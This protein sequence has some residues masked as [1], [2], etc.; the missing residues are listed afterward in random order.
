M[1]KTKATP[2]S[3]VILAMLLL[4]LLASTACFGLQAPPTTSATIE[5]VALSAP[6][7]TVDLDALADTVAARVHDQLSSAAETDPQALRAAIQTVL[8]ESLPALDE[9]SL[10]QLIDEA[11]TNRLAQMEQRTAI[12]QSDA[13]SDAAEDDL[14]A[15]L[16][17]LY[18]Q[19]NPSVVYI[20]TSTGGGSGFVYDAAGHIVTNNHVISGARSVEVVFANGDRLAARLVG[21]DADS[22]LATAGTDMGPLAYASH[23]CPIR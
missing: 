23:Q 2:R 16:V 11:V 9:E 12:S 20:V 5:P 10:A 13:A 7:A 15:T 1:K 22:D 4:T 8:A 18:Q 14:Q 21:A 6:A 3:L 17:A 19:A